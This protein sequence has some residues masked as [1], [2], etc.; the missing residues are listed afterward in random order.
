M[1]SVDLENLS[2]IE[3]RAKFLE[4]GCP[5]GPVTATTRKILLKKLKT[6]L[7]QNQSST[8]LNSSKYDPRT[9]SQSS[10]DESDS[11]VSRTRSSRK[12][13]PPP[14]SN[15]SPKRKSPSRASLASEPLANSTF[16][17]Q[18]N[19]TKV[20]KE[21]VSSYASPTNSG[22]ESR[23]STRSSLGLNNSIN[24]QDLYSDNVEE[25]THDLSF[26]R[27]PRSFVS[28]GSNENVKVTNSSPKHSPDLG[29]GLS[30]AF[31]SRL[32]ASGTSYTSYSSPRLST[33]NQPYASDFLRRLSANKS[34]SSVGITSNIS[35]SHSLSSKLLDVKESDD[36]DNGTA[37]VYARFT[38]GSRSSPSQIKG[39]RRILLQDSWLPFDAPISAVLL[40][41]FSLFFVV[42]GVTYIN[43][44]SSETSLGSYTDLH[45]PI[46]PPQ[47][48]SNQIPRV[49]C[50]R[51]VDKETS[52][53]VLKIVYSELHNKLA[54]SPCVKIGDGPFGL[55]DGELISSV[56]EAD[57]SL[58][59]WI[60]DQM[61]PNVKI[62]ISANPRLKL[63]DI[64]GGIAIINPPV[65]FICLIFNNL[66]KMADWAVRAGVA[67]IS[68]LAIYFG[69]RWYMMR[70]ASHKQEVYKLVSNIIEIVAS[71]SQ[72]PESYIAISHVRDQLI[73]PQDRNSMDKL[74]K[75]AVDVLNSDSRI[76]CEQQV[77][78]GEDCLVWRWVASSYNPNK[79][80]VWQGQ[81]FDTME[82]SVNSLPNSPTSCLKIRHMF[83]AAL[84]EGDDWVATV[85]DAIL[86][87]C[88]DARILHIAVERQSREGC[89]Y[90]KCASP[91]DA[92]IA[93]RALHGSWFDSNLVTVKYIREARYLERFPE[94]AKCTQ[95]LYPSNESR[96]SLN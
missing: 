5:V 17:E 72:G 45:Y 44:H 40:L 68:F 31:K 75:D 61:L 36:E 24:S 26:T 88:S 78:E 55:S 77:V 42:I 32:Q 65:P 27:S 49:N 13:M 67:I 86:E 92:G 25:S 43:M 83:D 89:V 57:P 79:R 19:V 80:K 50:I 22:F 85:V 54:S 7:E 11:N 87:K 3:I 46:C 74:W 76:R 94:S 90:M 82:G 41:L 70:E 9:I 96:N 6:L 52:T 93:Y 91:R 20:R 56:A 51:E 18:T 4:L 10:E 71:Q 81:A 34:V 37:P 21:T 48:D 53:K 60:T 16:A 47:P 14:R 95:P 62:L 12:S 73:A 64:S 35:S 29:F 15:K 8:D 33:S 84:E 66:M 28:Q 69:A 23:R 59:P 1:A 38:Q 2:D 30:D 63:I 58:G 39:R